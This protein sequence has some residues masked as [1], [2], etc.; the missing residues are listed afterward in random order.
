MGH[1]REVGTG[2]TSL[3][4]GG[5]GVG[6]PCPSASGDLHL[7][8]HPEEDSR[9]CLLRCLVLVHQRGAAG[10]LRGHCKRESFKV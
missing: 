2:L 7:V 9:R 3:A 6:H 1:G 8:A 5:W 4:G 10:Q